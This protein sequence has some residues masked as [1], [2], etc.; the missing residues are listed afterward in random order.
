[1]NNGL[2]VQKFAKALNAKKTVDG[3]WN[4]YSRRYCFQYSSNK[5]WNPMLEQQ[6]QIKSSVETGGEKQRYD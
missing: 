4:F 3:I 6:P 1:M 5:N 2:S